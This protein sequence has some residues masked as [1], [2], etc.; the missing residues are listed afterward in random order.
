MMKYVKDN[1]ENNELYCKIGNKRT[2]CLWFAF[3]TS[4]ELGVPAMF[5]IFMNNLTVCVILYALRGSCTG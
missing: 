3:F 5:Q 1:N 2:V 4:M